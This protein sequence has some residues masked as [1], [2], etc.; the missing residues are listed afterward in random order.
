MKEPRIFVIMTKAN[1]VVY[2]RNNLLTAKRYA[3]KRGY[4]RIAELDSDGFMV[5]V[6]FK[7]FRM[8]PKNQRGPALGEYSRYW[9]AFNPGR[10]KPIWSK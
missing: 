8:Y 7:G 5:R 2:V 3:T 6:W 4:V 10:V 1:K 9:S